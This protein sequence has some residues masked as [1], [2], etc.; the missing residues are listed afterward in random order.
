EELDQELGGQPPGEK[1]LFS[2]LPILEQAL[3]ETLRLYPPVPAGQRRSIQDSSSP[4][5]VFLPECTS[6]TSPGPA[7]AWRTC[8]TTLT[9][10]V[11]SAWP[12]RRGQSF[13][14]ARMSPSA[15]GGASAW[16]SASATWRPR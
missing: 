14:G 9:A 3:D 15:A 6:N 11:R 13:A 5:T 8:S 1:Q 2:G 10:S 12:A 16:E 4:V 7:I